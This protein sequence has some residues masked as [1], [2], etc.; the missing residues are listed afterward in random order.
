MVLTDN[1][2]EGLFEIENL[3]KDMTKAFISSNKMSGTLKLEA[4]PKNMMHFS[5]QKNNFTGTADLTALRESMQ[6]LD[7]S[8]LDLNGSIDLRSLPAEMAYI[9][10]DETKIAQSTLVFDPSKYYN[11]RLLLDKTRFESIVDEAGNDTSMYVR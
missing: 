4:F 6:S 10:L 2:F 8:F 1:N 7:L 5:A 9:R 11:L 3:P